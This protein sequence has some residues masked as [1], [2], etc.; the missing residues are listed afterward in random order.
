MRIKK[1]PRMKWR[2]KEVSIDQS[3][4][5][6]RPW[7]PM[8]T[9]LDKLVSRESGET[10]ESTPPLPLSA[11]SSVTTHSSDKPRF[12]G[13][14]G[15]NQPSLV[16]ICSFLS[17]GSRFTAPYSVVLIILVTSLGCH[18]VRTPEMDGH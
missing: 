15:S 17:P 2:E 18:H 13:I 3:H 7:H 12:Y 5:G 14:I 4:V 9:T 6:G 1:R 16:I 10:I 11:L 8:A